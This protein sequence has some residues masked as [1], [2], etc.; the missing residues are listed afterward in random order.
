SMVDYR[1]HERNAVGANAGL[2]Q[3]LKRIRLAGNGWHREQTRMIV[4]T[5]LRVATDAEAP[6]LAWFREVLSRKSLMRSLRLARRASQVRRRPR[7][8]VV[9][10]A[11][12][13]SGLW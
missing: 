11:M 1:Q 3:A 9:M 5:S 4:D 2:G 7:D 6:R 12:F 10:F 13:A 8:R